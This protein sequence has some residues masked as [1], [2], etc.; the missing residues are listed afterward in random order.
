LVATLNDPRIKVGLVVLGGSPVLNAGVIAALQ[1]DSRL[2]LLAHVL[3]AQ[4]AAFPA[5]DRTFDVLALLTDAPIAQALREWERLGQGGEM[6]RLLLRRHADRE[7]AVAAVEAGLRG[8][9][10]LAPL[11]ADD[12][13]AGIVL[14]ARYGTW[15]CPTTTRMLLTEEQREVAAL[16]AVPA[17]KTFGGGRVGLSER[18][19]AVLL[20]GA[21]GLSEAVIADRLCL[22]QSTVKTYWR[23]ICDKFDVNSRS[24]A[25]VRGIQAGIVPDRRRNTT[26]SS[27]PPK[28]LSLSR[29]AH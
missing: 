16:P 25:I 17:A 12:L 9:A 19:L 27:G 22:A 29:R 7:D 18:E 15:L 13:A 20:Y 10:V 11:L 4:G 8:Y 5:G 23:R 24:E 21:S 3:D 14:L 26:A 2:N 28:L 6:R 1:A